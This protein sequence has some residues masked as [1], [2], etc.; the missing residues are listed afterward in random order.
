MSTRLSLPSKAIERLKKEIARVCLL[1]N[2][3]PDKVA[4]VENAP[5]CLPKWKA[6]LK[7]GTE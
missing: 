5:G 3:R 2:V 7:E 1:H 4:L 6:V